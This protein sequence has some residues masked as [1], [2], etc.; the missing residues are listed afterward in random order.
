MFAVPIDEVIRAR[1]LEREA[2]VDELRRYAER[3]RE[4]LGKVTVILYGSY[5]RGDFN[6]WSDVDA[7][8]VSERFAGVDFV[9]RCVELSD[10]PP[11][12]EPICWT[13]EEAL[14]ALAKPWWREALR[15]AVVI[16]DDYGI[17][18]LLEA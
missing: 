4:R 3:L 11:R 13:P 18:R 1:L 2:V 15:G 16:V 7:V 6:L 10:A 9:V 12:L 5:A 8:V 17:A 14:K